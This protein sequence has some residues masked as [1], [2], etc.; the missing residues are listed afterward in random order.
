MER[1]FFMEQHNN[2][3]PFNHTPSPIPSNSLSDF[4]DSP[5]PSHASSEP[6]SPPP[7][8]SAPFTPGSTQQS[9]AQSVPSFSPTAQ[10]NPSGGV[11]SYTPSAYDRHHV[12]T[13]HGQ[14][15]YSTTPKQKKTKTVPLSTAILSSVAVSVIASI[16]VVLVMVYGMGLGSLLK[17]DGNG[18]Q[19]PQKG[20]ATT[21]IVVDTTAATSA[22]AVAEKAGPSVVGIVVTTQIN[23][24][25]FGT[26]DSE[27]EG[28]GIIYSADGYIVT[29]YHV[30]EDAVEN[31][32][33]VAVYL[34]SDST[35]AVEAQVI[36]YDISS[37]LA[38]LKIDKNGLTPMET[39]DSDHLKVGQTAIAI[40][41][42]GGMDFMGSVSMGI[43]S[44]LDR[45][46]Q[47]ENS[48]TEI[49]LIQTDAAINPGNSGGALVDIE[50]KLIGINS[51]KMASASFEGMGFAIPVNDAVQIIDRIIK[52]IDAPKPYLGV[53]IS[54]YYDA[55]TL[56]MMGY[57]AGVVVSSVTKGSPADAAGIIRSDII[58]HINDV[59][60]T[61]YNQFNSEKAK[62]SPNET[63]KLKIYRRGQTYQVS[64]TL[65]TANQ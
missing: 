28:S 59:A 65:G 33:S 22:E 17:N 1:N 29:N 16:L 4:E 56:Q 63:I 39:G 58:T 5:S 53:E 26:S 61:N 38:V 18:S 44:G 35:T 30:I 3:D 51:A 20:N 62:Y 60:V 10:N 6:T 27:S 31:N 32:G 24:Y 21:N 43:I 40:G 55:S 34:P 12:N 41:N 54:T 11:N 48:N 9:S 37:D 14:P 23:Y 2:P 50:G 36:G 13:P 19:P 57:P 7:V 8:S 25:F 46:L 47:L 52:N 15:L 42:P 49:N 45:T 64:I